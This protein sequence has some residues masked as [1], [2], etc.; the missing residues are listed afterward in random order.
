MLFATQQKKKFAPNLSHSYQILPSSLR[1]KYFSL[2]SL[3]V[4]PRPAEP[5]E[6]NQPAIIQ[7][8]I[9]LIQ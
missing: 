9:R 3:G 8:E 2:S 1:L 5:E 7:P 6:T 4:C